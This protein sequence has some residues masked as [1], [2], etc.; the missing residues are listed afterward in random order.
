MW[1]VR[2]ATHLNIDLVLVVWSWRVAVD[3]LSGLLARHVSLRLVLLASE[4]FK[5]A[6]V[7]LTCLLVFEDAAF[8]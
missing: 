2:L 6:V 8:E 3:D 5:V 7:D 1:Q 4:H